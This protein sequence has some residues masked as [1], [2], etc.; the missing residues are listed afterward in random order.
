MGKKRKNEASKPN[1]KQKQ[2]DFNEAVFSVDSLSYYNEDSSFIS[3]LLCNKFSVILCVIIGVIIGTSL[4][5]LFFITDFKQ[6][7]RNVLENGVGSSMFGSKEDYNLYSPSWQLNS[8]QD[9]CHMIG[10]GG[11]WSFFFSKSIDQYS[12]HA[13]N[14]YISVNGRLLRDDPSHPLTFAILRELIIREKG[15]VHPDL[16]L[17]I[18]APSGAA[19]GLGFVRDN[20][21]TCQVRCMP[22]TVA[23]KLHVR[24]MGEN[25]TFPPFWSAENLNTLEK[26]IHVL[27]EQEN[28]DEMYRQETV[29]IK[30][31]LSIQMTRKLAL[32]TLEPLIPSEVLLRLPL[33]ELDD[34]ALL[35][36]L[37]AHER[38]IGIESAFHPYISSLPLN[39]TCGFSPLLRKEALDTISV[40]SVQFGMDVNGWPGELSKATDRANIM[41]EGL[42]RDYG[43]YVITPKGGVSAYATIQ[44]AFCHVASRAT[45]GSDKHGALRLVPI[46]D[47]INH[48]VESGGIEELN[49][50]ERLENGNF[51][52]ATIDDS[53]AFIVR[54][55]LHGRKRPLRKGQEIMVNYNVPNY[56][57]LDWFVSMGFV[58]PERKGRWV[59]VE[60]VL[61]KMRTYVDLELQST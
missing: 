44:W 39:P 7:H 34:A 41:A 54:S 23:E 13:P 42:S 47:L 38:S 51:V 4:G 52:D 59:K 11:M 14:R 16:G 29:L 27:D 22:G 33:K 50:M 12:I 48:D 37:L 18:P 58:P 26:T 15:Y 31:P 43:Q 40:M 9:I 24:K 32:N 28:I 57:P 46:V 17:L 60:N 35:V 5:A 45:A 36:L 49:G 53:G 6:L 20:Y 8:L 2:N 10:L 30:I 61:P 56:S 1:R 3:W 19:R 25:S 21:N 55:V